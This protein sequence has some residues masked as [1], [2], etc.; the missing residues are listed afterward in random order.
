MFNPVVMPLPLAVLLALTLLAVAVYAN[1]LERDRPALRPAP[2]PTGRHRQAKP[3]KPEHWADVIAELAP[4]VVI[5]AFVEKPKPKPAKAFDP[6]DHRIPLSEV[7][8]VMALVAATASPLD[9]TREL[10]TVA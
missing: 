3:V 1:W 10:A 7:E 2:R 6:L 9:D 4:E 8:R 5:P